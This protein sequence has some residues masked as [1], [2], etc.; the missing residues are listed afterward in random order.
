MQFTV[1]AG[2]API[3]GAAIGSTANLTNSSGAEI[4]TIMGVGG[5]LVLLAMRWQKLEDKVDVA[6]KKLESLPCGDC[7]VVKHQTQKTK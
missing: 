5:V 3:I 1:F 6:I 4:G 7:A 2:A